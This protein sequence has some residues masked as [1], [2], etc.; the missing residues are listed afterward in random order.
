MRVPTLSTR[1]V[2]LSLMSLSLFLIPTSRGESSTRSLPELLNFQDQEEG[3]R[4]LKE[5]L[6]PEAAIVFRSILRRGPAPLSVTFSLTQALVYS[7]R[8][9]EA[10]RVLERLLSTKKKEQDQILIQNRIRVISRLFLSNQVFQI[11]QDGLNLMEPGKYRLARE[12]F[13]KSLELEPDN[14]EVL[15][16]IG[17]CLELEQDH[18]SATERLRIAK[19]LNPYE[20]EIALWLGRSHLERG[21]VNEALNELR[22]ARKGLPHSERAALWYADALVLS[23][24]RAHAIQLMEQDLQSQVFHLNVLFSLA[25]LRLTKNFPDHSNLWASRKELQLLLSRLEQINSTQE[26][27]TFEGEIGVEMAR[28]SREMREDAQKLVQWVDEKIQN[29]KA[30]RENRNESRR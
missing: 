23:G 1:I 16:R 19:R 27:V 30:L 24:Q 17:Q 9:E 15:L 18:D 11:Y 28:P 14:A 22:W 20:P 2:L 13:E 3:N 26:R 4:L 10:I 21:E 5:H 8:R 25:R 29:S 6:W 7:G 12:R